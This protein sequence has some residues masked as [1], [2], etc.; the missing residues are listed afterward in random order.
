MIEF[1][2]KRGVKDYPNIKNAL[3]AFMKKQGIS[4][5]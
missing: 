1:E 4:I 2:P 5:N 3:D